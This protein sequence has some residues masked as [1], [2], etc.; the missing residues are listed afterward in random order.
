[1]T[2]KKIVLVPTDEDLVRI[3]TAQKFKDFVATNLPRTAVLMADQPL[4]INRFAD[5][6]LAGARVFIRDAVIE[7]QHKTTKETP[8]MSPRREAAMT[9]VM[10]LQVNYLLA[11]GEQPSFTAQLRRGPF[12]RIARE[13]LR[14]LNAPV[15]DIKF[16]NMLQDRSNTMTDRRGQPRRERKKPDPVPE[17]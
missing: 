3:F 10:G 8:L 13:C 9:F 17:K 12:A 16:I 7:T 15:D 2:R 5:G 11:T 1:M 14:L 6:A 4:A